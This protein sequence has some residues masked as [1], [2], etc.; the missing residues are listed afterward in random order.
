MLLLAG[1]AAIGFLVHNAWY[2]HREIRRAHD[3]ID[4]LEGKAAPAPA[5]K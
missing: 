2:Q 1:A 5:A 3:R 4:A